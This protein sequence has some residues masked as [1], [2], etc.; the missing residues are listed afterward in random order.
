MWLRKW[1]RTLHFSWLRFALPD[2]LATACGAIQRCA[3]S[4]QNVGLLSTFLVLLYMKQGA[5]LR[6]GK[7]G[8]RS[9]EF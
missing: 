8:Q 1:R 6:T 7:A 9:K 5:S 3:G 2:S 4:P